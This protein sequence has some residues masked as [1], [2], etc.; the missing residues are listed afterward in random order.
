MNISRRRLF[1]MAGAAGFA[2]RFGNSADTD[3]AQMIV[4]SPR[5]TDLEMRLAGFNDEI[6]PIERFFVRTHTYTP[7]VDANAW[8]IKVEGT[9]GQAAR[10]VDGG[11]EEVASRGNGQRG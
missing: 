10:V 9:V 2:A 6:T 5:P 8:N 3:P 4:R 7:Q 1:A 11:I